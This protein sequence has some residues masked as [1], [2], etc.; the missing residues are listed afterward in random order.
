M[1]SQPRS[2]SP[3][4]FICLTPFSNNSTLAEDSLT[5]SVSLHFDIVSK[6]RLNHRPA[7]TGEVRWG[8]GN[9]GEGGPEFRCTNNLSEG[10]ADACT[11]HFSGD[12]GG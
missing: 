8:P 3:G 2:R 11:S 5:G 9:W 10:L 4:F 6:Q 12:Y 1:I 7:G